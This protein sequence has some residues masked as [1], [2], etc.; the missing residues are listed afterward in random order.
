VVLGSPLIAFAAYQSGNTV[1]DLSRNVPRY[2]VEFSAF[3]FAFPSDASG[4]FPSAAPLA[5]SAIAWTMRSLLSLI[6]AVLLIAGFRDAWQSSRSTGGL[7]M[8]PSAGGLWRWGW[9]TAGLVGTLEIGAFIYA[10]RWLPPD[11][12]HPTIKATKALAVLPIALA[13]LGLCADRYW[14][15]LPAPG[16]WKR[17][18]EGKLTF[19]ALLATVP[20]ALLAL[21]SQARP[22]LNQRGML[23]ASP[24]LFF[25]LAHGLLA[26]RRTAWITATSVA[27][28]AICALSLRSYSSMTVDPVDYGHFAA[29]LE[30]E[31]RS[32][33]L[34]FVRKAWYATPILYYLN[35]D[36]HR[37]IGRN[38]SASSSENPGARV[39]V[40]L[41]YDS[42]PTAE[43][44]DALSGYDQVRSITGPQSQALLYQRSTER[45][46]L[47][48]SENTKA[49]ESVGN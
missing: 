15:R 38:Y 39:W 26:L 13:I 35:P 5:G 42:A 40:V 9:I 2:L 43:M 46:T 7:N 33:D 8:P 44:R 47:K 12:L 41:L 31:I 10:T 34:V 23:F 18:V 1:A 14:S 45:L 24:Y 20:F 16:N 19:A 48:R 49:L 29:S 22:L 6:A 28:V 36:Q 11:Q 37:I 27:L 21:A 3:A 17:L 30:S 32:S 25:I 4:F